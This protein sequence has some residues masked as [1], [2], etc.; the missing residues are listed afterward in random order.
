MIHI[1]LNG[2]WLSDDNFAGIKDATLTIRQDDSGVAAF[3]FGSNVRIYSGIGQGIIN[4]TIFNTP[5]PNIAFCLIEFYD[6]C[7]RDDDG[8]FVKIF[9]GRITKGDIRWCEN[10]NE[11]CYYECSFKDASQESDFLTCIKNT[12]II[13][14]ENADGTIVSAGFNEDRAAPYLRYYEEPRPSGWT[15]VLLILAASITPMLLGIGL[16]ASFLSLFVGRLVPP[17][18]FSAAVFDLMLGDKSHVTPYLSSYIH[19]VCKLCGMNLQSSVFSPNGALYNI[20]RFD[21]PFQEG[22]RN[23]TD[24]LDIFETINF[25]NITLFDLLETLKPLNISYQIIGNSL[26]VERKDYFNNTIWLDMTT[27]TNDI[28]SLCFEP[29]EDQLFSAR[30]YE[31]TNDQSDKVGCELVKKANFLA[32]YNIP[33]NPLFT[34]VDRRIIPYSLC[35]AMSDRASASVIYDFAISPFWGYVS[36]LSMNQDFAIIQ[37]GTFSIPKLVEAFS[38]NSDEI[39]PFNSGSY[40][41]QAALDLAPH[42]PSQTRPY[43][44]T[45][46]DNLLIIDDIRFNPSLKLQNFTMQIK[47]YCN[48][49]TS[50][51]F[52]N[53]IRFNTQSFGLVDGTITSVEYDFKG[54]LTIQGKI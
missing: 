25:P 2:T 48:Y 32:N 44:V 22:K 5:N 8:G 51:N 46:Y 42:L 17:N 21:A 30:L 12:S 28:I 38:I 16:I 13:Q 53:R 45:A 39:V 24:S 4:S 43:Q 34:G 36:G 33:F 3:S 10:P 37:S 26:I 18:V 47:Y 35:R 31:W 49:F 50:F 7:C 6:D 20:V 41:A 11:P 40:V 19:N 23:N 9:Q 54:L 29:N 1:R 27:R 52:G 14:R 15:L